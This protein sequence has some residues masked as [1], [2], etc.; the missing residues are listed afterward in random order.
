MIRGLMGAVVRGGLDTAT[1][2]ILNTSEETNEAVKSK[3]SNFG[4]MYEKYQT[5]FDKIS[6]ENEQISDIARQL[7]V[8]PEYSGLKATELEG[9]AQSL[10]TLSDGNNPMEFY[11]NNRDTL[12]PSALDTAT[13]TTD[14]AT[15]TT[16]AMDAGATTTSSA[17]KDRS[18]M[19]KL[20]GGATEEETTALAAKQLGIS[21]ERYNEVMA[22]RMPTRTAPTTALTV[23][24][25]DETRAILVDSHSSIRD[26][27]KNQDSSI[28]ATEDGRKL[29]QSYMPAYMAFMTGKKGAPTPE[30]LLTLQNSI[31]TAAAPNDASSFFAIYADDV[32]GIGDILLNRTN[33]ISE[34]VRKV[35]LPLYQQ[36]RE[37]QKLSANPN[38]GPAY[39]ADPKNADKYEDNVFELLEILGLTADEQSLTARF[40]TLGEL[41]K[42]ARTHAMN[43]SDHYTKNQM[44]TVFGLSKKLNDARA[45]DG[46]A[47]Q[48]AALNAIENT[49]TSDIIPEV[50]ETA[51]SMSTIEEKAQNIATYMMNNGYTGS[52]EQAL[53]EA[54]NR[55]AQGV[56]MIQ[57]VPH[58]AV[59]QDGVEIFE[60]LT[61]G[62]RT[63]DGV[64]TTMAPKAAELNAKAMKS[65]LDSIMDIGEAF[66]VLAAEPNAFNVLGAFSRDVGNV[67]QAVNSAMGTNLFSDFENNQELVRASQL[68][69]PLLST[70]KDRLFQDPR[71]SDRDLAIVL[72]YVGVIRQAGK[73]G[74]GQKAAIAALTQIRK[75][76]VA[77][78]MMRMAG[79]NRDMGIGRLAPNGHVI[80]HDADGKLIKNTVGAVMFKQMADSQG[81]AIKSPDEYKK[82]YK[83]A[84]EAQVRIEA[85]NAQQGDAQI[86]QEYTQYETAI[87]LIQDTVMY[88][89]DRAQA[90]KDTGYNSQIFRE[91]YENR[92]G[93]IA[94]DNMGISQAQLNNELAVG[95]AIFDEEMGT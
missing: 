65:N 38:T 24:K 46:A 59:M 74:L 40:D 95:R 7:S 73:F 89:L 51:A 4:P 83:N 57:N 33:P 22:G 72:D 79:A 30:T 1:Q 88:G 90:Y 36:I 23:G 32:K 35:A 82:L 54:R 58:Q 5:G 37:A 20:F 69:I 67:V 63:N 45:M 28:Y 6:K 50:P 16:A 26:V 13:A 84:E 91:N 14:V 34:E 92:S 27:I 48:T 43:H 18:F 25:Q 70:A 77:D 41:V 3:V 66:V 12:S 60:P 19:Q 94:R 8:Q 17:P 78:Q 52:K 21:V 76:L 10:L 31:L 39:I 80:V 49:L 9:I 53:I 86:I 61:L 15:Q 29:A 2:A 11:L 93:L 64:I 81:V 47:G 42:E 44:D 56:T 55:V 85:G 71:L 62:L 68:V 87:N 75:A